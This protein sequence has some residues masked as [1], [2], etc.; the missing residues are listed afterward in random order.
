MCQLLSYV[1]SL[2]VVACNH[3]FLSPRNFCPN[4]VGFRAFFSRIWSKDSE[5]QHA[6]VLFGLSWDETC[7][8]MCEIVFRGIF[9]FLCMHVCVCVCMHVHMYRYIFCVHI[10]YI[11]VCLCVCI[12]I[13]ICVCVCVHIRTHIHT[14]IHT[15]THERRWAFVCYVH[16]TKD[17]GEICFEFLNMF[18][19]MRV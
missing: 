6:V 5:D 7:F 14:Y 19:L 8:W 12:Y 16:N 13:Y 2:R 15:H 18:A 10:V 3:S 11:C 17:N 1:L 4:L 9:A